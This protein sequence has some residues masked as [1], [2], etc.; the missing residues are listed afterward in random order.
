MYNLE[1]IEKQLEPRIKHI[2][3]A[4]RDAIRAN[5]PTVNIVLYGSQARK[6]ASPESDIDLLVLLKGEVTATKK[7]ITRDMLY[8][9]GLAED[10]VISTIIRS[11]DMW[12]SPISKATLLYRI[13]QQKGIQVARQEVRM[14]WFM[15]KNLSIQ[16]S[17]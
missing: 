15:R 13:I 6:Q 10:S 3:L 8:D 5:Y 11:P 7:R 12:Y 4:R 1:E 9:I 2:V 14:S 16:S 17:P